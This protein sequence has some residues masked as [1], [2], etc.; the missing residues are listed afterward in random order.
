MKAIF[1]ALFETIAQIIKEL[2][3]E[4]PVASDADTPKKLRDRWNRSV[5]DRLDPN[6]RDRDPDR[7]DVGGLRDD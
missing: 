4:D 5:R 3:R 2:I 6:R 7:D 1:A